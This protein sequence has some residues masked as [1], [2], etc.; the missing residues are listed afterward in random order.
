MEISKK[1]SF[2]T[3][4]IVFAKLKGYPHWPAK[5]TEIQTNDKNHSQK[6]KV[7]FFGD[8]NC[9]D[10]KESDIYCYEQYKNLYGQPKIDHFKNK[11]FNKAL[12]EAENAYKQHCMEVTGKEEI[13]ESDPDDPVSDTVSDTGSLNSLST[14][15]NTTL[16]YLESSILENDLTNEEDKLKMAATVGT[17]LLKENQ[18]LKCQIAILENKVASSEAMIEEMK[19][20]ERKHLKNIENLLGKL[21]D[22]QEQLS[23]VTQEKLQI[24]HIFEEHDQKQE[25]LILDYSNKITHLM[26]TISGLDTKLKNMKHINQTECRSTLSTATQ[27]QMDSLPTSASSSLVLEMAKI[28]DQQSL[29]INSINTNSGMPESIHP[30]MNDLAQIKLRQDLMENTVKTLQEQLNNQ[31]S[32]NATR[33]PNSISST[34]RKTFIKPVTNKKSTRIVYSTSLQ[35]AKYRSKHLAC[36]TTEHSNA[37]LNSASNSAEPPAATNAPQDAISHQRGTVDE[38]GLGYISKPKP[39]VKKPPITALIRLDTENLEDFFTN[40]VDIYK[41]INEHYR[42][43]HVA[44]FLEAC[45]LKKFKE[46]SSKEA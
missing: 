36:N 37:E 21:E 22:T 34:P 35:A 5:I 45:H 25:L 26:Q 11:L 28:R 29:I 41:K 7:I 14:G 18:S 10:I 23:K 3:G 44:H 42:I 13:F 43:G 46:K 16:T 1:T 17:A 19:E 2:I 20:E 12:K 30:L 15:N 24:Q 33:P 8:K 40:H 27:T 4:E 39:S 31:S 32:M 6:Y 38:A 9:A